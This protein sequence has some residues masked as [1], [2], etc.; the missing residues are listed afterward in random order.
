MAETE[1]LQTRGASMLLGFRAHN[2]RSFLEPF[3]FSLEATRLS[4]PEVARD[5]PWREGGKPI[6]VLPAAGVFGA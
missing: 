5:I 1:A 3:N 2:A 6:S 4:K